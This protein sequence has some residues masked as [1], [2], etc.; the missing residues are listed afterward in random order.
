MWASK[1]GAALLAA[2]AVTLAGCGPAGPAT[3]TGPAASTAAPATPASPPGE[4]AGPGGAPADLERAYE[5]VINRVLPSI[6]QITTGSGLGS[7][8]IYD[9]DGHIIT[10]AHVVGESERFEVT[11]ATGGAPRPARL[12]A[13]FEAGDLAVIKVDDPAGLTPAVMGDSSRLR[14][15]QIVLAMGNPLGL[16][17][18]VTQGI[19]SALGR[20]VSEPSDGDSPG[21]TIAGAIQTS[22]SINPGNSGG[23]LVN[24][25]GE[26]IGVPTLTAVNP[27]LG[28]APAPGIGFAIPSNTAK[29]VATQII[30]DGRVVNTRRAALG[31]TVRTVIDTSGRPAGVGVVRVSRGSGAAKAGIEAGDVITSVDG[32]PTPTTQDLSEALAALRPGDEAKVEILRPGGSTDTV[33]V[34]LGELPGG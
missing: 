21:A 28:N 32:R 16:S 34:T 12:V 11:L 22:A 6:V 17:G 24:L 5:Q 23:A 10:N 15:G 4:A 25:A 31:V 9:K 19:V 3:P 8:I 20:T 1:A 14:V 18:S 33:A 2:V 13:S 26:V 30:R 29:D 27:E 7:G